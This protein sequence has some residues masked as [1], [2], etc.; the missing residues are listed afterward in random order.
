MEILNI[1][2]RVFGRS[3]VNFHVP[4]WVMKPMAV[5]LEKIIKPAPITRDQLA[6]MEMGNTGDIELMMKLFVI[7][8]VSFEDGLRKY[9]RYENGG[10][11]RL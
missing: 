2:K 11:K 6:M 3:T 7:D 9:L 5:C 10:N 4:M 8:P 1:I